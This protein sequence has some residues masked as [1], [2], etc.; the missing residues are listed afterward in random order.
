MISD[1][2]DDVR[3]S[4]IGKDRCISTPFGKKKMVYAD[5]TA[6]GKAVEFI[7]DYIEGLLELYGNTH[8]EDD[9]TGSF[10]TEC[11]E[12]AEAAI[13][14]CVNAGCD[15][16]LIA[17]GP[18]TT[19]AVHRLQQIIGI[20][21]PPVAKEFFHNVVLDYLD[22][23][24]FTRLKTHLLKKCPVIFVGPYEHHS[25]EVSWRECYAEVVE[26]DL[27]QDGLLDLEDLKSK[28]SRA[29]YNDRLK[30]GALSAA[31]NV[32][33]IVTPAYE[34][35][36]ILHQH[37]A[38]AF[39]DF[40]AI[41]PY[42]RIDMCRSEEECFDA[43]YFSP[44]KFIGG[45]GSAGVLIIKNSIYRND[46]PPTV[47]A[48][49]TVDFVNMSEQQYNP[50]IE[51][52]EKSGTPGILQIMRTALA[53]ELK[54]KLDPDRIEA[55]EHEYIVR[56]LQKFGT[57]PNIEIAGSSKADDRLAIFSFNL[58]CGARYLHPRFTSRL[59]N[60]LFGIQSRAGCSCAGPY[61]HRILNIS[62]Q[63]SIEFKQV[64]MNGFTGVKP[65][66]VR[67]NFHFLM[68]EEEFDFLCDAILFVAE[69]GKYF[70]PLYTFDLKTGGWIHREEAE[71]RIEF[72]IE[73]A[74]N[75]SAG[76]IEEKK[77]YSTSDFSFVMGVAHRLLDSIKHGFQE[78]KLKTTQEDLIPYVYAE[79]K[80]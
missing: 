26:I 62:E 37:G 24:S 39:F 56:A 45:P 53:M 32:S 9:A 79:G 59:L 60:D 66:W 67:I 42:R 76:S 28:V 31:S 17:V 29:E 57:N 21:I 65:G 33:G 71:C 12:Q 78:E 13:K 69:N 27:G 41:A 47:G 58:K 14:R 7:E 3:K 4:V 2:W 54:E 74:I 44:H 52:R 43:I 8:T 80:E 23:D 1:F 38:L 63:K 35:A 5:Y 46:L 22:E 25:N 55:V 77:H 70:L 19:S 18:G 6:S 49:G 75:T 16:S 61:G 36:K 34:A 72:G 64:I 50:D 30:I 20:Y 48:G 40:A 11:L 73:K 10:T 51:I 15:H 68:T